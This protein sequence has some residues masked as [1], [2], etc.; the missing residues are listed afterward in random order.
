MACWIRDGYN[1]LI[2]NK[3]EWNN[4]FIKNT[5]RIA[6]FEL[7]AILVNAYVVNGIFNNYST[8]YNYLISN[9]RKW[10]NCFIKN[11]QRIAIFEL[12]SCFRW[13]VSATTFV[14]NG[15]WAHKPLPVNQSRLRNCS[16]PLLVFNNNTCILESNEKLKYSL[17]YVFESNACVRFAHAH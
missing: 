12:I 8:S 7:P 5:Q 14:E 6:I 9:K 15:I 3:H 10:N 16:I 1:Y 11:D 13:R 17:R 4:C 2:S